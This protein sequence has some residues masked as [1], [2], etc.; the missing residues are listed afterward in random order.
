VDQL[1]QGRQAEAEDL[2]SQ[3]DTTPLGIAGPEDLLAILEGLPDLGKSLSGAD[4]KLGRAVFDAFRV[5]MEIDRNAGEIKLKALVSSAFTEVQDL[6]G[7]ATHRAIAG[8]GFE[9]ATFG[10]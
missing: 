2:L 6:D 5:R 10:L 8:A 7:L 9:P 3:L 1:P 4:P